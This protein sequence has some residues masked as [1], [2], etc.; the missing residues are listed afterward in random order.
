[1]PFF[2]GRAVFYFAVWIFVA[3]LLNTWSLELDSGAEPA[4]VARGSAEPRRRGLV[5]MG[6]TIT[7]AAVDWAMSLSPH[8][9]STIYGVCSWWARPS[10]PW[11]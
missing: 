11:P 1:M 4:G 2:L 5:L 10:R 8:W 6:L 7:F 9:F 3:S